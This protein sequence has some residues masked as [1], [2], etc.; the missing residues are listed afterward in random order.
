MTEEEDNQ[1]FDCLI[2]AHL[3]RVVKD[4]VT[5]DETLTVLTGALSLYIAA[6]RYEH[7][8]DFLPGALERLAETVDDLEQQMKAR[9]LW[10]DEKAT[11]KTVLH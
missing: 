11:D 8:K 10:K 2:K 3:N 4:T 9:G 6:Q 1:Q 7:D 5:V